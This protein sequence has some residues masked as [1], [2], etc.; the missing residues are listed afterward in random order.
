MTSEMPLTSKAKAAFLTGSGT[1][2]EAESK[3]ISPPL[4]L[5]FSSVELSLAN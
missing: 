1:S 5:V 4:A 2:V 3:V